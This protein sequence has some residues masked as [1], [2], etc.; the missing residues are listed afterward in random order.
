ML[1]ASQDSPDQKWLSTTV[2]IQKPSPT[3]HIRTGICHRINI[4]HEVAR[5]PPRPLLTDYIMH[6]CELEGHISAGLPDP[7]RQSTHLS[8]GLPPVG[9]LLRPEPGH[10]LGHPLSSPVPRA[11]K[12]EVA[13]AKLDAAAR[14]EVVGRTVPTGT[15]RQFVVIAVVVEPAD[16]AEG[17]HVRAIGTSRHGSILPQRV[18]ANGT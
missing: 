16:E 5:S 2:P 4:R 13:V 8:L 11:L 18:P 17:R 1:A 6:V 12:S 9:A 15:P 14:A 7:V 10:A 3:S